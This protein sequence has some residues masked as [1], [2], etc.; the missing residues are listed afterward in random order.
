MNQQSPISGRLAI[1]ALAATLAFAAPHTFAHGDKHHQK[2]KNTAISTEE[3]A[4]GR[5]GDPKHVSRTIAIDMSDKMR[6]SPATIR[7]KQG[8]T[9]RFVVRNKGALKHEMVLGTLDDLK[10][11]GELMK[12]FP[13]MEHDE[14]YMAHVEPGVKEEMVWQFTNAGSFYFGCLMPGHFDAGMIGKITVTKG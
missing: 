7:I 2:D 5:E 9:I 1:A 12:K 13:E 11:H 14:P 3:H 6:F 10:K 8:E 4:F